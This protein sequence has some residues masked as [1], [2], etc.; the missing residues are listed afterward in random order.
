MSKTILLQYLVVVTI[1]PILRSK[2]GK[3][4][5]NVIFKI[6]LFFGPN[7]SNSSVWKNKYSDR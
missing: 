3:V 5:S 7:I 2:Y 4:G 6:D 1:K